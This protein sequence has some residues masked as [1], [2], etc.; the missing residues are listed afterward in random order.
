MPPYKV[1]DQDMKTVYSGSRNQCGAWIGC[2]PKGHAYRVVSIDW[3]P[4]TNPATS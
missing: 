1:I 4:S 2:K 3:K